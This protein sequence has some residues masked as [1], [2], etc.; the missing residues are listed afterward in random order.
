MALYT[1]HFSIQFPTTPAK[2]PTFNHLIAR[3]SIIPLSHRRTQSLSSILTLRANPPQKYVYPDPIPEFAEAETRKFKIELTK[4]LSKDEHAFGDELD[5][6]VNVCAEILHE[7][8]RKDYGGPG[9][10]LVEPFT[11]MLIA[12]KDNDLPNASLVARASLLWAQNCIDQDWK[13]W[14]STCY[15]QGTPAHKLGIRLNSPEE[16]A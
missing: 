8:L 9:T 12:L 10:L 13:F 3:T 6:V 5:K 1:S 14:N 16:N 2:I 15:D 11:Y 4:T 7:F